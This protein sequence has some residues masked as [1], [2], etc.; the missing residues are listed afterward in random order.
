MT[1]ITR[2]FISTTPML[3]IFGE[4]RMAARE[5]NRFSHVVSI[6]GYCSVITVT[7]YY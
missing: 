7:K 5:Q 6:Q 2:H 3:N 1:L 4:S